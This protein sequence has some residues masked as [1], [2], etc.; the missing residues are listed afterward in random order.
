MDCCVNTP[1]QV[2]IWR[3]PK[4]FTDRRTVKRA[5]KKKKGFAAACEA[6][7]QRDKQRVKSLSGTSKHLKGCGSKEE[8][9]KKGALLHFPQPT[10]TMCFKMNSFQWKSMASSR[11]WPR[12]EAESCSLLEFPDTFKNLIQTQTIGNFGGKKILLFFQKVWLIRWTQTNFF[13]HLSITLIYLSL[14]SGSLGTCSLAHR[15]HLELAGLHL[16]PTC[17]I[18]SLGLGLLKCH[19]WMTSTTGAPYSCCSK[20]KLQEML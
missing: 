1:V 5:K 17:L 3:G 19:D 10:W 8:E 16:L 7:N 20:K 12:K 11:I 4:N 13:R 6:F 9:G 2:F 18:I 15:F 14:L